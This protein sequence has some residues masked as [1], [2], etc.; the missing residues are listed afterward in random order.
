MPCFL[1]YTMPGQ[2]VAF[3][4]KNRLKLAESFDN[5]SL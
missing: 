4:V 5:L 1:V 3:F 2:Q